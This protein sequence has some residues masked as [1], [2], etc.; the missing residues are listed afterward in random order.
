MLFR[1]RRTPEGRF[2]RHRHGRALPAHAARDGEP[3]PTAPSA[4]GWSAV[5][6]RHLSDCAACRREAIALRPRRA[7]ARRDGS[8]ARTAAL[9][10]VAA[11]LPLPGF[12]RRRWLDGA[13][14]LGSGGQGAAEQ[15]ATLAGK[16]AVVLAA[17]VIAGGGAAGV[18]HK[19][20]RDRLRA[21]RSAAG[22]RS[23]GRL[24]PDRNAP[25]KA[26]PAARKPGRRAGGAGRK[27]FGKSGGDARRRRQAGAGAAAG[28]PGRDRQG[29]RR[30]GG[31]THRRPAGLDARRQWRRRPR[32]RGRRHREGRRRTPREAPWGRRRHRPG[33]WA[34]PSAA[35]WAA[36]WTRSAAAVTGLGDPR[37]GQTV[38]GVPGGATVRLTGRQPA[39]SDAA[40]ASL[41]PYRSRVPADEQVPCAPWRRPSGTRSSSP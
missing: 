9:S 23:T 14:A 18:A 36:P 26:G 31:R 32:Q 7:R 30:Q 3:R 24:R 39:S 4:C 27:L 22:R 41:T 34:A 11:F 40:S 21:V 10:R 15:G 19:T 33:A 5:C 8:R 20:G 35:R 38:T 12:L 28:D 37:A 16:A 25:G 17:A 29:R 13:G 6:T 1:A 2:R